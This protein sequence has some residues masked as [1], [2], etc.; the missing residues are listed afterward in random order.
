VPVDAKD[1]SLCSGS[2]FQSVSQQ[3]AQASDIVL[4][5]DRATVSN[6]PGQLCN[7]IS[8][9]LGFDATEIAVPTPDDVVNPTDGGCDCGCDGG[10]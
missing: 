2:A 8:I 3:I 9:G 4:G 10:T 6:Q 5:N 1:G 7:A